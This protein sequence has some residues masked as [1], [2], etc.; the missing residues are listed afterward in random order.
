MLYSE[1]LTY[2]IISL[3]CY[4]NQSDSEFLNGAMAAA[5]FK[6]SDDAD[7]ADIIIINTCGFI[8]DAK[9]ES[10]SVIFDTLSIKE[11]NSAAMVVVLGC[12]TQRYLTNIADEIP[13]IDFIYGIFDEKFIPEFCGKF[14]IQ[15]NNKAAYTKEP[16]L[17]NVPYEYLKIADGC[18][19][20]CSYCAIPIIRGQLVC[21]PP[22][23]IIKLANEAAAR[24]VKELI[25][26]A[27][28]IAAYNYDGTDLSDILKMIELV[29]G[30]EWIRLLYCHPDKIDDRLIT[31]IKESKKILHYIDIPFQHISERILRSMNRK[32][33]YEKY[34]GLIQK[35]RKEIPD[36]SIRS[37]FMVGYP[38]ET[39]EE[40][41][42][43]LKF[44][45]EASLDKAGCFMYSDE[46]GTPIFGKGNID[47]ETK[48]DRHTMVMQLQQE[49]SAER[50][51]NLVGKSVRVLIES[52]PE[53][54]VYLGHSEYDAPEI[55]GIFCLTSKRDCMNNIVT[56]KV[57]ETTEY[58]MAGEL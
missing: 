21:Y 35:L 9:K 57:I 10:I 58:D 50:L 42:E 18:S 43:L 53:E 38:D 39:V 11:E 8:E 30:P 36:I 3:G 14:S 44:I 22:N 17:K 37:T 12:L 41:D 25:I 1:T 52:M 26:I 13:E 34:L 55:D 47:N 20:N 7:S 40:F 29:D 19:N 2:N 51:S 45:E 16:L 56:V 28:D 48:V 6:N 24:N 27:Q 54:G 31:T 4:K 49:I 46:E 5:G 33:N 23:E 15:I 32:G